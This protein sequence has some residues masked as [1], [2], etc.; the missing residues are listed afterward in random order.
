MWGTR[1][2]ASNRLDEDFG[3]ARPPATGAVPAS[4]NHRQRR[5]RFAVPTAGSRAADGGWH[6]R[7]GRAVGKS[8]GE[9]PTPPSRGAGRDWGGPLATGVV[10]ADSPRRQHG[11]WSVTNGRRRPAVGRGGFPTVEGTP[12]T[13]ARGLPTPRKLEAGRTLG[14]RRDAGPA[15]QPTTGPVAC[16]PTARPRL[17]SC[18]DR[19]QGRSRGRDREFRSR[20]ERGVR[21][22]PV[23]FLERQADLGPGKSSP[24]S[25]GGPTESGV[26]TAR[27]LRR[28]GGVS[29]FSGRWSF[30]PSVG[31]VLTRWHPNR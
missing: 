18:R 1:A 19:T 7:C 3:R 16:G 14:G 22:R 13:G 23:W 28:R 26:P 10:P 20:S 12:G 31:D 21:T 6:R 27:P 11:G 2:P 30:S 15:R 4:R 5:Q 9:P 8:G 25:A 29:W 17:V 24:A